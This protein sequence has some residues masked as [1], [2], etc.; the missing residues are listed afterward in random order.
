VNAEGLGIILVALAIAVTQI[1]DRLDKRAERRAAALKAADEAQQHDAD[2]AL[3]LK[4]SRIGELEQKVGDLQGELE[5][6]RGELAS[7]RRLMRV[8][9]DELAKSDRCNRARAGCPHR[10][11]PGDISP[12]LKA[13]RAELDATDE[14]AS[15]GRTD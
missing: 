2:R 14:A 9:F 1:L 4:D 15:P 7:V 5:A 12:E 3:E 8:L 13:L 11:V 10:E 6:T